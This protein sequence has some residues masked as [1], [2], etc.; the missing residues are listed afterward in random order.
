MSSARNKYV[1]D[2]EGYRPNVG[3]IV[4]NDDSQVLWARRASRDGWQFPQG[5]MEPHESA[6]QAAYRELQEEV[7]LLPQHVRLVGR[8]QDWL[9]YEVPAKLLRRRGYGFCGQKQIWFLF[10]L[11]GTEDDICLN[12]CDNPEFDAWRWVN[13]WDPLRQIVKFKRYVY[14]QALKELKPYL[15]GIN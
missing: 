1:I 6:E 7:G 13:Y 2:E 8:T 12:A 4:C 15:S 5:G 3:I 10:H 11:I 9:R 14:E